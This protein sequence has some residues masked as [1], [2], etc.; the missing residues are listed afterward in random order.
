MKV[1]FI[2]SLIPFS[3]VIAACAFFVTLPKPQTKSV[4]LPTENAF[5]VIS[6]SEEIGNST[7]RTIRYKG[8]NAVFI[9][10]ETGGNASLVR[11]N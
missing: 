10:V 11:A 1:F 7:F 2:Y 6:G 9:Y 8:N 3:I 4:K 5:E